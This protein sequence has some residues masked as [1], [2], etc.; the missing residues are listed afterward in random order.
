MNQDSLSCYALSNGL[1]VVLDHRPLIPLTAVSVH[2]GVGFRSEPEGRGG[3]AHL[4]EHL[5]FQGSANV[6]RSEHI[7]VVQSSG[8]TANASTRQD[9]TEYYQIAPAAALERLLFLEA[10]RMRGLRLTEEALTTQT[11]VV[12]EEIKLNVH[13]RA[14]GGF[15][16]TTLPAALFRKYSNSHNG[17]GEFS[18]L[19]RATPDD[20]AEFFDAYY[21]PSNAVLTVVGDIGVDL[22]AGRTGDLIA[23]HFGGIPARRTAAP[24]DLSEPPPAEVL[25]HERTDRHAPFPATALGYR[26]PDPAVARH[27]YLACVVLAQLLA[28]DGPGGLMDRARST[29]LGVTSASAQAGFFGPFD[30]RDPDTFVIT[31]RHTAPDHEG[32]RRLAAEALAQ[33]AAGDTPLPTF[34]RTVNGLAARWR[35]THDHVL[36]RTRAL[37]AFSLLHD[38]PALVDTVPELLTALEP[39]AVR[40]A[41]AVLSESPPAMLVLRTAG[42]PMPV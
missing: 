8:G 18:E 1:R 33:T 42:E 17:Y 25:R 34:D 23:R 19:D 20:C 27:D 16:W 38:D 9:Y 35:R 22:G 2:Y 21:A 24:Q 11:S 13:D 12:K 4:F 28:G 32:F 31:A 37:G 39:A 3:F 29:E 6:K 7:R 10:D 15:P 36:A 14:Y 26:L 41:A 5:M 40:T 30:A